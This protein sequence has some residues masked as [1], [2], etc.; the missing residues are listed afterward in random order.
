MNGY[1]SLSVSNLH[2]SMLC[3][4][5]LKTAETYVIESI[6]NKSLSCEISYALR[7]LQE[8]IKHVIIHWPD[9]GRQ[10]KI[11]TV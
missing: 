1:I 10:I 7:C 2:F 9:T 4:I 5:D 11:Y 8:F 6:E 3:S